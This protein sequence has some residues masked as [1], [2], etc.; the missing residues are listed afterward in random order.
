MTTMY[1]V[2]V[3]VC[4]G[5]LPRSADSKLPDREIARTVHTIEYGYKSSDIEVLIDLVKRVYRDWENHEGPFA[6]P[7]TL[8]RSPIVGDY[9]EL[10]ECVTDKPNSYLWRIDETGF[11]LVQIS[12]TIC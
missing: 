4:K 1:S 12:Q 3:W 8:D 2:R 5:V 6:E 10:T 9:I 7:V 11:S